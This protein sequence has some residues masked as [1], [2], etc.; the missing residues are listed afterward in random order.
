M[1]M[2]AYGGYSQHYHSHINSAGEQR[3]RGPEQTGAQRKD[4]GLA[5]LFCHNL[6]ASIVASPRLSMLMASFSAASPKS[7][8]AAGLPVPFPDVPAPPTAA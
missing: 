7:A 6:L 4:N 1:E 2:R 8:G 3:R 5:P